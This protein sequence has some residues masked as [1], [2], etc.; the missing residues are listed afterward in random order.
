MILGGLG[1]EMED[2]VNKTF[3]LLVGG[4]NS[5]S[6]IWI[7]A[8]SWMRLFDLHVGRGGGSIIKTSDLSE[9]YE[10]CQLSEKA[11]KQ[12]RI[13]C[14]FYSHQTAT[15]NKLKLQLK[16]KIKIKIQIQQ[17]ESEWFQLK[18]SDLMR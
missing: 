5:V 16:I 1:G 3:N 6:Q 17:A 2:P 7:Q 13:G 15:Q 4:G 9:V 14:K 11:D 18:N 12:N 8:N 10:V